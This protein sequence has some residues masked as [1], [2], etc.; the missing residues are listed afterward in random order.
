MHMELWVS[1]DPPPPSRGKIYKGKE[2]EKKRKNQ[3]KIG[4]MRLTRWENLEKS[5]IWLKIGTDRLKI[6]S[7][8][9]KNRNNLV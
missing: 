5:K 2:K 7:S 1:F 4:K 3:T 6:E 8:Y 9:T